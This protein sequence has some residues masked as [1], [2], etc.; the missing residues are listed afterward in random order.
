MVAGL[1]AALAGGG[2]LTAVASEEAVAVSVESLNVG[3]ATF[4]AMQ[5]DPVVDVEIAY[6]YAVERAEQ[7]V[8]ELR[9]GE[10]VVAEESLRTS[11]TELSN[12]SELSG[13]VV[14]SDAWS[15]SDFTVERGETV[16]R[17]V[18][19]RALLAARDTD[20]PLTPPLS[21]GALL[22]ADR[23]TLVEPPDDAVDIN[24]A[25]L[26]IR[27]RCMT[28]LPAARTNGCDKAAD[29]INEIKKVAD[30]ILEIDD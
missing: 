3:N 23:E 13:R 30:A 26:Q 28:A 16:T 5:V 8:L 27:R 2:G 17:D 18:D 15:A 1:A 11:T 4:Q 10:T 6:E 7:V 19:L 22:D 9:V 21:V 29:E 20:A 24:L 12:T 14:R 25:A